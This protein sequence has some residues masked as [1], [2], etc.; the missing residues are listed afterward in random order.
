MSQDDDAMGMT[1][2]AASVERAAAI[3][4]RD[5]AAYNLGRE[6]VVRQVCPARRAARVRACVGRLKRL[7]T[8]VRD[9]GPCAQVR[10]LNLLADERELSRE[11]ILNYIRAIVA[12][13][14]PQQPAAPEPAA[15]AA[16]LFGGECRK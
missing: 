6:S 11:E 4:E 7:T 15:G 8:V 12:A 9:W 5:E 13:R 3:S 10:Q 2:G 16:P 1:P 14:L